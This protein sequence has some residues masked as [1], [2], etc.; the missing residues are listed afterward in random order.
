MK[1]IIYVTREV[2][3]L[4]NLESDNKTHVQSRIC[5][6]K[7]IYSGTDLIAE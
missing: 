1:Q 3:V 5:V 4:N 7:E 2:F 6:Y